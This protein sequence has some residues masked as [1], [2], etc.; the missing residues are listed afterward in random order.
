MELTIY[1]SSS[2]VSWTHPRATSRHFTGASSRSRSRHR[3][4]SRSPSL[5]RR[6]LSRP[7]TPSG[8]D[9]EDPTRSTMVQGSLNSHEDSAHSSS[10]IT[11]HVE[12]PSALGSP[13]TSS[14]SL[15]RHHQL[16]STESIHSSADSTSSRGNSSSVSSSS[17]YT[18]RSQGSIQGRSSSPRLN[19]APH[20]PPI[21]FPEPLVSRVSIQGSPT[22]VSTPQAGSRSRKMKPM[23][24][25]QVSRYMK[26]G[27]V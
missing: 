20:R 19:Q 4:T 6:H 1:R 12:P 22:V 26:K 15:S 23:H 18:H 25:E 2:P 8:H 21:S 5:F 10:G 27:D 16:P 14:S 13:V 11:V 24:S 7:S 17:R 3:S 9:I